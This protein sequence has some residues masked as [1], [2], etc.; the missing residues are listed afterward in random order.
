VCFDQGVDINTA[1]EDCTIEIGDGSYLGP[2]VCMAGPGNI[3]IGKNCLIALQ[4]GL[5]A[6]NHRAYG[7]SREGI[8]IEDN[9]WLGTGVKILDGVK[10]GHGSV[11]GAG[12]VVTKDIPPS[13]IAVGIP[14]KVIKKSKGEGC[15]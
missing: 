10:I 8:E 13:S 1:G 4:S 9:C 12:S 3:K 7:L 6:N 2:Y 5:Y 11:I 14:A 15:C